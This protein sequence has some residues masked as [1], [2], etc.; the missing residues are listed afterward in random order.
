MQLPINNRTAEFPKG[1]NI[2]SKSV[3]QEGEFL[4]NNIPLRAIV[5]FRFDF[6]YCHVFPIS[7]QFD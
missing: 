4:R 6:H 7:K 1:D 3:P 2:P 5:K